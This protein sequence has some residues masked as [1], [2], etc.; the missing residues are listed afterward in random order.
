MKNS[1]I[2]LFSDFNTVRIIQEPLLLNLLRFLVILFLE[3]R[4]LSVIC[5]CNSLCLLFKR[6]SSLLSKLTSPSSNSSN[7]LST[8]IYTRIKK[9]FD[10][11][12][13]LLHITD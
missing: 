10:S 8:I 3:I 9:C 13:V 2:P 7:N 4:P 5:Y 11:Q 6:K 1:S 12:H